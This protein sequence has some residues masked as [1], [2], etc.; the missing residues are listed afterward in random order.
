MDPISILRLLAA[1]M[2]LGAF[3]ISAYYRHRAYQADEKQDFSSEES[4]QLRLRVFGAL[5]FYLGMLAWLIYPPLMGWSAI[6][7]WP[8]WLRQ[9]GVAL[10]ALTLPLLYWMF[11]SLADNIT[12]TVTT[13]QE[14]QLVSSGPYRYI[15]HP[16]YT[17]GTMMFF[18]FILLAGNW[19]LMAAAVLGLSAL[20]ARTPQE[21]AMLVKKFGDEYRAYMERTGRH[22]PK[23]RG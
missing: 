1:S 17:F 23:L 2:I 12:P 9:A 15:R 8:L 13:R 18:G 4:W 19:F 14:H 3:S 5:T 6:A 21:E 11:S 22:L 10:M 7:G 20:F 16:L